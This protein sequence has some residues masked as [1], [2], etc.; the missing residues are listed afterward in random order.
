AGFEALAIPHNAN[1][2]DGLMFAWVDSRGKPIDQAYAEQRAA[3]EPLVELIQEKGQSETH[4]VLSPTDEFSNFELMH[5]T[6]MMRPGHSS[7][8]AGSY[9][10]DA[11]GRGMEIARRV[12]GINPFKYG[13]VGGSDS[14]SGLSESSEYAQAERFLKESGHRPTQRK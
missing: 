9:V 6:K 7:K 13:F 1:A 10:R 2:S 5:F 14:H 4:P 8:L 3:N 11:L 12:G